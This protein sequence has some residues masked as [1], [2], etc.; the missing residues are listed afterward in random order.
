[1]IPYGL[2]PEQIRLSFCSQLIFYRWRCAKPTAHPSTFMN[3]GWLYFVVS[4]YEFWIT[5]LRGVLL[6]IMDDCTS[7]SSVM[8]F[9]W[10][11]FEVFFL[12]WI[13]DD[14]TSWSSFM[15]FRW[16]YVVVFFYEFWMTVFRGVQLWIVDDCI[17]RCSF[18]YEFWMTLLRR[19]LLWI[20][21]ESASW[22][23]L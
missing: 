18:F 14:C 3:F 15:N 19:V 9:R 23:Y 8:N 16:L 20:L 11:Y 7:W 17:S 1:M 5:V 4:F 22:W 6:W 21:D 10:L 2:G 13:L 12:L